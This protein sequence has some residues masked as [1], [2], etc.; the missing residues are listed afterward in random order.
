MVCKSL[1]KCDHNGP[2]MINITKLFT[3]KDGTVF[4]SFGRVFSGTIKAGQQIKVLGQNYT[5]DD[6]EDSRIVTAGKLWIMQSRYKVNVHSAQAGAWVMIEG[7]DETIVK[8]AT[9]VDPAFNESVK[10]V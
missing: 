3:S 2:L 1:E 8:T 7:V 5:K 4:Y 6:E 10:I 9:L